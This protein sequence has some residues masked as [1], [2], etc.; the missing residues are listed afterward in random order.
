M[1]KLILLLLILTAFLN[2]NAA[3]TNPSKY[4]LANP[5]FIKTD[6]PPSK[7]Q[8]I[9]KMKVKQIET[10][11][12]R[13]L[14]FKERIALKLL[15]YQAKH[16]LKNDNELAAKKGKTSLTLGILAIIFVFVFFPIAIPLGI[17]AI[18]NGEQAKKLDSENTDGK[19]GSVLGIV[20]LSIIAFLIIAL[21]LLIRALF[22]Y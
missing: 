11:L 22:G 9:A 5:E 1:Q 13:K 21:I 16:G 7:L 3:I 17:L 15:K 10:Y 8:L 2:S 14:K 20:S 12:G 6:N 4:H 19:T 18:T